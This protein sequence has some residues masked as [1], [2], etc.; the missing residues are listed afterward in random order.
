MK[1]L[2]GM[3]TLLLF[4]HSFLLWGTIPYSERSQTRRD[5]NRSLVNCLKPDS[6]VVATLMLQ[7]VG[8]CSTMIT[9][10]YTEV[11][12]AVVLW[13]AWSVLILKLIEIFVLSRLTR[14]RLKCVNS[15]FS[16]FISVWGNMLRNSMQLEIVCKR[17]LLSWFPVFIVLKGLVSG[18]SEV[19]RA[20]EM[21]FSSVHD[22]TRQ[23]FRHILMLYYI[24][25]S[26]F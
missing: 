16:V 12:C 26:S 23:E 4:T 19:M 7:N 2:F 14:I 10:L 18:D 15:V 1:A 22:W 5:F 6:A 11:K 13:F 8:C 20:C 9:N 24:C 3:I 21:M 25:L 17:A